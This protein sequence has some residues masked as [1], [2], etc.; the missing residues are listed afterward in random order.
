MNLWEDCG[1]WRAEIP[2]LL[3]GTLSDGS[4]IKLNLAITDCNQCKWQGLCR[5]K[6]PIDTDFVYDAG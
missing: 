1:R 4:C 6:C 3:T 2:I 5:H